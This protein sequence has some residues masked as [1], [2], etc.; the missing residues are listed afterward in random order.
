M[1][2]LTYVELEHLSVVHDGLDGLHHVVGGRRVFGDEPVQLWRRAQL[3]I[4]AH[5]PRGGMSVRAW[6][7]AHER[8]QP[9]EGIQLVVLTSERGLR[10][11]VYVLG[12]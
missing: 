6:E 2:D 4:A 7:E 12:R 1:V 10:V 11:S 3:G 5:D 8:A 9:C